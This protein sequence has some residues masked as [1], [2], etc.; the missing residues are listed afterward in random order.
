MG[1]GPTRVLLAE[2]RYITGGG[3][4]VLQLQRAAAAEV[5]VEAAKTGAVADRGPAHVVASARWQRVALSR[6]DCR[7]ESSVGRQPGRRYMRAPRLKLR[8]GTRDGR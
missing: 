8:A 1:A 7:K 2:R 3:C 6:V 5:G 4:S